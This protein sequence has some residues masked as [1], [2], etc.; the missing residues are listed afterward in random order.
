MKARWWMAWLLAGAC[1]LVQVAGN[2]AAQQDEG[3]ILRP[4]KPPAKPAAATLLA[5]CDLACNWKLDGEAKGHIDAGG[6]AKA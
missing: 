3:P 5:M 4:K 6:S 1:V 2:A